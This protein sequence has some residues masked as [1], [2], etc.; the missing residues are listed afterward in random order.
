MSK[1]KEVFTFN[2]NNIAKAE[3]IIAK[4]PAGR[5]KSAMLPLLELAQ[6]QNGGWLSTAAIE[7]V[8]TYL[9]EPFMRAYEVAT[10]YTMFNLKPVGRYHIQLCGTTPCWLMGSDEIMKACQESAQTKCGETSDDNLF[11]ISEVECLGACRNAPVIQINDDF[12]E[13]LTA[14]K[15]TEILE[16]LRKKNKI[17]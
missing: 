7:C 13:D 6:K 14:K 16:S 15:V 12:Y 2:E 5:Q 4:Y 9:S 8:A 10:F 1:I 17:Q 3:E 11:T